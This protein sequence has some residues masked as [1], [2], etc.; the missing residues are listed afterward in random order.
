MLG[1][2]SGGAVLPLFRFDRGGWEAADPFYDAKKTPDRREA[3]EFAGYR[4]EVTSSEVRSPAKLPAWFR[5]LLPPS[6]FWK[7]V[8]GDRAPRI[9]RQGSVEG[10]FLAPGFP[11]IGFKVFP[12]YPPENVAPSDEYLLAVDRLSVS[13]SGVDLVLEDNP[14]FAAVVGSVHAPL[15][16]PGVVDKLLDRVDRVKARLKGVPPREA[17]SLTCGVLK[18]RR[19]LDGK[20]YFDVS[21]LEVEGNSR[22]RSRFLLSS[23]T[24]GSFQVLD[25][26]GPSSATSAGGDSDVLRSLIG[27]ASV[28]GSVFTVTNVSGPE[29]SQFCVAPVSSPTKTTCVKVSGS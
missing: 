15:R 7:V 24:D 10:K 3:R 23:G 20:N 18:S 9:V 13:V 28:E 5:P 8:D 17:D 4:V 12:V 26:S 29:G 2:V 11:M 27:F 25:R 1:V 19:P 22:V 16:V 21:C 6:T 14:L